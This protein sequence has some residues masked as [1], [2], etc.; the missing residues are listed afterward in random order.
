M[1]LEQAISHDVRHGAPSIEAATSH[2]TTSWWIRIGNAT[3]GTS[4][5]CPTLLLSFDTIVFSM[6]APDA[7]DSLTTA[8]DPRIHCHV[9]APVYMTP[10]GSKLLRTLRSWVGRWEGL[11][12][13]RHA[14]VAT[15]R[16]GGADYSLFRRLLSSAT[17]SSLRS[18]GSGNEK[19]PRFVVPNG[20]LFIT[21][22][23]VWRVWLNRVKWCGS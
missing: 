19:T 13:V 3:I 10:S 23:I 5:A 8:E 17:G 22:H 9:S 6:F 11:A 7:R 4:H 21:R 15:L 1:I 18:T 2:A 12:E 14:A 20:Y 16:L